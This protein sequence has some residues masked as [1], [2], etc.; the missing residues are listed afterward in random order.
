MIIVIAIT[1]WCLACRFAAR[2]VHSY[3]YG[4]EDEQT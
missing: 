4:G 2:Y 3:I 1:L